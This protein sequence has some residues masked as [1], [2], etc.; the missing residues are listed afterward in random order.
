MQRFRI[1][2]W[3]VLL[4]LLAL[5]AV[6]FFSTFFLANQNTSAAA[7][8]A[9]SAAVPVVSGIHGAAASVRDFFMRLFALRNVDKQY[10][11]LKN[12]VALLELENQFM[13]DLQKENER[14]TKLLGFETK[15]PQYSYLPA[16]VVGKQPGSWFINITLDQ[17]TNNGVALDMNVV[18]EAGLVGRVVETGP[19]W[20]KVMTIIDRQSAVSAVMDRSRDFGIVKGSGDP[21]AGE[22]KC[23]IEYLQNNADMIPGDEVSTSDLG[24]F[25]FKGILIGTVTEV[26]RDKNSLAVL[27]PAVDFARLENVLIIKGTRNVPTEKKIAQD[28]AAA[29]DGGSK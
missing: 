22:P 1:K 6:S 3:M 17:G 8:L 5:L 2:T 10:E 23:S 18:N 16:R 9:G 4:A 26:S 19:T 24:G 13:G 28:Q 14:L 7:G 15:Y 12:R 11:E 20:C 25:F 21:Q 27:S 29:K